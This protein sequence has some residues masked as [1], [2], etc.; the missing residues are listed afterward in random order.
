MA[1]CHTGKKLEWVVAFSNQKWIRHRRKSLQ[2]GCL[3][4]EQTDP[5]RG[6]WPQSARRPFSSICSVAF[7]HQK[8]WSF[9]GPAPPRILHAHKG[10]TCEKYV[11][12]IFRQVMAGLGISGK[13]STACS[14]L[15]CNLKSLWNSP[16]PVPRAPLRPRLLLAHPLAEYP[17][18]LYELHASR[19]GKM[20]AHSMVFGG[21]SA[22]S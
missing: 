21:P 16:R 3:I 2:A 13:A 14:L 6:G 7:S 9:V 22:K 5:G 17:L 15:A 19:C 12:G 8:E 11:S 18:L 10:L 20:R 4:L 1:I